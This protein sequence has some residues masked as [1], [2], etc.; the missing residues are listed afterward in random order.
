[1]NVA[2][3]RIRS[4]ELLPFHSCAIE[5]RPWRQ[6]LKRIH[7]ICRQKIYRCLIACRR[8]GEIL[9][10]NGVE[11]I[12]RGGKVVATITD[13]GCFEQPLAGEFSLD[14]NFPTLRLPIPAIGRHKI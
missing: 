7:H 6:A 8:T 14:T 9:S 4:Q 1:M 12:S 2:E 10:R 13:I 5:D 11:S 3:L